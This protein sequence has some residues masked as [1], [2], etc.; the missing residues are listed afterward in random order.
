MADNKY[1]AL[2]ER[3]RDATTAE[4]SKMQLAIGVNTKRQRGAS[5]VFA[6]A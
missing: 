2:V 6:N 1:A 4:A 3:L 5:D